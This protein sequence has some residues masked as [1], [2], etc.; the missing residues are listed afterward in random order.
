MVK[1]GKK[2]SVMSHAEWNKAD[3][4]AFG[5]ERETV[6]M[7]YYSSLAEPSFKILGASQSQC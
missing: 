7:Q 2:L 5:Y 1:E 3:E 6:L 4:R